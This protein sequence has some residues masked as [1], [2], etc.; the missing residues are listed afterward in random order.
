G[1]VAAAIEREQSLRAGALRGALEIG[2]RG[3]LGRRAVREMSDR[4]DKMGHTLA[5]TS[6]RSARRRAGQTLA[7]AGV[8]VA[9]LGGVA[10]VFGDGLLAILLPVRAW[11][12]TL[13]P[14]IEFRA[15]PPQVM[16][17]EALTIDIVAPRRTTVTLT[18][19]TTGEGW[20]TSSLPV[21]SE[22]IA[23]TVVGPMRGDLMLVVSD[24]RAVTDT[25]V[26]KV[27][28]RPFVGGISMRATY[29]AYLGRPGEGLPVGEPARVPRG[30][31][32][33]ITGRAS[34]ELTSVQLVG[35][36][37]SMRLRPQGHAFSGRFEATESGKWTWTAVGAGGPVADVPLPLELEVVPDSI[38]RVELV[39]PAADT[40]VAGDDRIPLR[41]TVS[42]D[43]GIARVEV[44]SWKQ[45]NGQRQPA[46]AQLLATPPAPV[47]NG[48]GVLDLATRELKPGDALHIKVV[49]VDNS[50]WRQQGE[51][52][53]LILKIPTMEERRA[54]ARD[55]ADSAVRE[56]QA[57]TSAQ[58]SLE[59]RTGEAARDRGQR[60]NNSRGESAASEAKPGGQQGSMSY[61]AAE[62]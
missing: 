3:A 52:R 12:G 23:R 18:Q 22:G 50:P 20:R 6:R 9:L 49:A 13:L 44:Q 45:G 59:Q 5:P 48:V 11:N 38:P 32:V 53:E 14:K 51:S 30:T 40:L 27:T 62:Q 42:D 26:V 15:L 41:I 37:T 25:A 10:P 33:D 61:E 2:D 47:W 31:I 35:A 24:G 58:R 39:S 21:S 19:R 56:A 60:N 36:K 7:A 46:V 1:G 17:G 4:L 54:M 43:H 55:A 8:G 57:T 28:D 29:P 34:T 16:R